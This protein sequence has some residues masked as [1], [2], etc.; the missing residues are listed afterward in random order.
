MCLINFYE[1]TKRKIFD[2]KSTLIQGLQAFS[3][4]NKM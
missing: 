4:H 2:G 3:P 1:D